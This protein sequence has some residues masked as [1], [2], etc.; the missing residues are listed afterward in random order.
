MA[1]F[2]KTDMPGFVRDKQTG[3]IINN[4]IDQY[5]EFARQREKSKEYNNMKAELASMQQQIAKLTSLVQSLT[6]K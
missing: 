5:K 4:N 6:E 2:V 1:E 3:I